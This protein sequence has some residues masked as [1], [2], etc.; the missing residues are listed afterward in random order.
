MTLN[1][2]LQD[3]GSLVG[4]VLALI[5]LFTNARAIT[6][7]ARRMNIAEGATPPGLSPGRAYVEAVVVDLLL[8][9]VTFGLLLSGVPL[10]VEAIDPA[11]FLERTGAIRSAFALCWLLV[12]GLG[13][14]QLVTVKRSFE[15]AQEI[16]R[17]Q[18]P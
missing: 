7:S 1:D 17:R 9:L 11:T 3:F 8:C 4:L 16:W 14:W 2:Q 12:L 10:A 18:V 6:V 5:A 13:L 15:V